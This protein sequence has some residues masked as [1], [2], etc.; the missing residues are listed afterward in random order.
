MVYIILK[1][2]AEQWGVTP[3]YLRS[4]CREGKIEGAYKNGHIWMIPTD[5]PRPEDHRVT[6]GAY[7]DWRKRYNVSK[8]KIDGELKRLLEESM[9]NR[10]KA[11]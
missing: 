5:A 3:K 1:D 9:K 8:W 11:C 2:L 4:L 6:T 7:R 10:E